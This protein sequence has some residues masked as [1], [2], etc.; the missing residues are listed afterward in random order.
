MTSTREINRL[1]VIALLRTQQA[2]LLS[3]CGV[4]PL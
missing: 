3:L 4:R 2:S 1:G